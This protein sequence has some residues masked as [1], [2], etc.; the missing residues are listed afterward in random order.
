MKK[1]VTLYRHV[2]TVDGNIALINHFLIAHNYTNIHVLIL[3]LRYVL[4]LTNKLR[5]VLATDDLN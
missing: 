2:G 5:M 3:L 4:K 1:P